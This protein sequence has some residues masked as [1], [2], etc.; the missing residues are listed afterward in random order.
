MPNGH[1]LAIAYEAKTYDEA[2]AMG[3]KPE[4]TPKVWAMVRK[5]H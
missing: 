5:N 2:I 1:I 4:K 3:R